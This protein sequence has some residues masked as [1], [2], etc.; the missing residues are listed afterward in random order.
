[1]TKK[2]TYQTPQPDTAGITAYLHPNEKKLRNSGQIK[3]NIPQALTDFDPPLF[4]PTEKWKGGSRIGFMHIKNVLNVLFQTLLNSGYAVNVCEHQEADVLFNWSGKDSLGLPEHKQIFIEHGWMPRWSYQ[5]SDLGVNARSHC[6]QD[7]R[8]T[9]LTLQEKNFICNYTDNLLSMY[10]LTVNAEK[11]KQ[12]TQEVQDPFILFPLQLAMDFNLKYSD[13]SL[14]KYYSPD[15][16]A[17]VDFA[18]ACIDLLEEV[19]LP[20]PVIFK[21]HPAD[22]NTLQGRLKIKNPHHRLLDNKYPISPHEI[23]ASD[24]CKLV[25]GVNSNT[26]H[27]A[28]V[29]NIPG[30]ALGTLLWKENS[31]S[32]PLPK[33]LNLAQEFIGQKFFDSDVRCSYL[34]HVIKHQWFLHDFQNPLLVRELIETS[35]RCVPFDVR[36]KFGISLSL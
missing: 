3:I 1:M 22:I 27:E 19:S 6:A 35:G 11:T 20:L 8:S 9:A 32:R 15:P 30:I 24:L 17:T 21:Q 10:K 28:A 4:Y 34:L 33:D 18:Q 23:F 31:D 14:S 2:S 25:V 13:T 7:F 16:S 12:F 36:K 29:W 5:V 26:L